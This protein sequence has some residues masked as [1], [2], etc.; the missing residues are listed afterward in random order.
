MAAV[1]P[2]WN[3]PIDNADGAGM[4]SHLHAFFVDG[5]LLY[6]DEYAQVG[7]SPLFAFVTGEGV[8]SNHWP[9]GATWIQAP[10]FLLARAGAGIIATLELPGARAEWTLWLLGLRAWAMVLLGWLTWRVRH[11]V[12]GRAGRW[13]A[14]CFVFGTPLFYYASE[15]PSRPHLYGACV[16]LL[17]VTTWQRPEWGRQWGKGL[18]RSA[19]LGLLVGLAASV[20][21]QLA[22]LGL[23]ALH[24]AWT[25]DRRWP[26]LAVVVGCAAVWPLTNLSLQWW[27]YGERLS[28]YFAGGVTHHPEY[29]LLSAYHGVLW[30]CPLAL[31]GLFGLGLGVAQGRRGAWLLLL[32]VLWQL[33]TDSGY[34]PIEPH[35]VLGTRTWGGGTAFGPRKLV[36]ALPLLLPGLVWLCELARDRG[37]ETFALVGLGV[38]SVPIAVLHVAVWLEPSAAERVL[39]LS[40]YFALFSIPFDPSRWSVALDRRSV[41]LA[42]TFVMTIVVGLPSAAALLLTHRRRPTARAWTAILAGAA[43]LAHVW[44]AVMISRSE[45][46]LEEDPGRMQLAQARTGRMHEAMVEQAV[47]HRARLRARLGPGAAPP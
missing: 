17:L 45:A 6:D 27:M 39:D 32:L 34:R 35:T 46:A 36:D 28:D 9:T 2:W 11:L 21:P 8:V 23:L 22:P 30:W 5:D 40:E 7:M 16:V 13:L 31:L 47:Q 42:I 12:E 14:L 44:T 29:L 24:D 20:R 10:G 1:A 41:P 18:V 25:R 38:C 33:W 4:L 37:R 26:H 19:I 3:L 43:V 15:A